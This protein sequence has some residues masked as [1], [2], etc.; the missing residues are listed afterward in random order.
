MGC[1]F[2][3]STDAQAVTQGLAVPQCVMELAAFFLWPQRRACY[4]AGSVYSPAPLSAALPHPSS[5][6]PSRL[7]PDIQV[8]ALDP[9]SYVLRQTLSSHHEAPFMYLLFGDA[10][11]LLVDTGA[12][13]IDLAGVVGELVM[14]HQDPLGQALEL[15][16]SNTHGHS[17]HIQGNFAFMGRPNTTVVGTSRGA[18]SH[19]F[20]IDRWPEGLG[21]ID[22]GGRR[23]D[24]MPIPG[25]HPNHICFYDH[26]CEV[27]LTGDVLYAGRLYVTDFPEYRRSIQ[28]LVDF[29]RTRPV[30]WILGSHV[31]LSVLGEE[32]AEGATAHPNERSLELEPASL[33][34]LR[35]ALSNMGADVRR[36]SHRDFVIVPT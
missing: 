28:R 27:L 18:V 15:V 21:S 23:V 6:R 30:R 2:A 1:A 13:G 3:V 9:R 4:S 16:V 20:G 29:C 14:Q 8:Q 5:W 19:V 35:D 7:C 24:V 12:G 10:K 26:G 33:Y 22:L 31:E 32:F 25:H 11:A 34:A 36:E 17:D